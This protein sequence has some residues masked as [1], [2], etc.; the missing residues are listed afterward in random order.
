MDG[1]INICYMLCY[2]MQERG[3]MIQIR[4]RVRSKAGHGSTG[5]CGGEGGYNLRSKLQRR[6][7]VVINLNYLDGT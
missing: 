7:C 3:W 2:A 6:T 4:M 1:W 5:G